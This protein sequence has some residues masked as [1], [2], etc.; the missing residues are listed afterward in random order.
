MASRS[1]SAAAA[2][3][4][5]RKQSIPLN[6]TSQPGIVIGL[7]KSD[8][9]VC[10]GARGLKSNFHASRRMVFN[11][12]LRAPKHCAPKTINTA[13]V[14][15]GTRTIQT[16]GKVLVQETKLTA[17]EQKCY[18]EPLTKLQKVWNKAVIDL[19]QQNNELQLFFYSTPEALC[20]KDVTVMGEALTK[21]Q[22]ELERLCKE[23][24]VHE[25]DARKKKLKATS[26]SS[27]SIRTQS[28]NPPRSRL[29]QHLHRQFFVSFYM[30]LFFYFNLDF[31]S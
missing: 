17:A 12:L 27:S 1:Q 9:N 2:T 5:K 29:A 26:A 13:D 18:K 16:K 24:E 21:H 10:V 31:R 28:A 19:I 25:A 4:P 7:R 23:Q 8:S 6:Q 22:E 14:L 11:V 30:S 20:T 15:S 3:K